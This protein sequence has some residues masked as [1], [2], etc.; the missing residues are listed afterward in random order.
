MSCNPIEVILTCRLCLGG[1]FRGS[2]CLY[3]F[4]VYWTYISQTMLYNPEAFYI[5]NDPGT[6]SASA[7]IL[8]ES[9]MTPLL[10]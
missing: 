4:E 9:I 2:S 5:D 10:I 7:N 3:T 6:L 8:S 1:G